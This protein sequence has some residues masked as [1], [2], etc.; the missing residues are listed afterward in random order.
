MGQH[1]AKA[2]A[3][4]DNVALVAACDSKIER[5][6]HIIKAVD[7]NITHHLK[8]CY[9]LKILTLLVSVCQQWHIL[10]LLKHA[11]MPALQFGRKTNHR[12]S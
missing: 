1:H 8:K 9:R 10:M 5:F 7:T 2:Y 3:R 6:N 12:N 4:L 11:W